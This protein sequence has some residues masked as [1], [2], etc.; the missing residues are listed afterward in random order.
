MLSLR[1]M[2]ALKLVHEDEDTE[3]YEE[4]LEIVLAED[5]IACAEPLESTRPTVRVP[6][7]R[8]NVFLAQYLKVRRGEPLVVPAPQGAQPGDVL[9]VEIAIGEDEPFVLH[10]QL[11]ARWPLPDSELAEVQFVAG[12]LTDRIVAPLAERALGSKHAA[13]LFQVWP[14]TQP[15]VR[16]V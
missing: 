5:D 1:R 9:D 12:R 4:E 10:A 11:I 8:M 6:Y 13:A 14:A 2:Y 7:E 15:Q 16:A 3:I